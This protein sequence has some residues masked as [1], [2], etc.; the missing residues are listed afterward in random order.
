MFFFFF[1]DAPLIDPVRSSISEAQAAVEAGICYAYH[2]F[3]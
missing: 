2:P 3:W 1:S